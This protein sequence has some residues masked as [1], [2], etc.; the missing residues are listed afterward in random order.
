MRII[1]GSCKGLRLATPKGKGIRPALDKV[2][3]AIF[4][5]LWSVEGLRVL[6]CF[7]GTGNIG[8]EALS[9]GA[10]HTTFID[11]GR[12]AIDLIRKNIAICKFEDRTTLLPYPAHVA[13]SKLGKQGT[14]FDLI[15]VD[16][17]Y[18]VDLVNPTICQIAEAKLLAPGSRIVCEH[19]PKEVLIPPVGYTLAD[20]RKYGQTRISFVREKTITSLVPKSGVGENH[21]R[22]HGG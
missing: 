16:P 19:F 15:F 20:E 21:L 3:E 6:D 2:K 22:R 17:P 1:A 12:E 18:N 13:I 8:L 11:S 10:A 9:R 14:V 7:A 5:I 4:N